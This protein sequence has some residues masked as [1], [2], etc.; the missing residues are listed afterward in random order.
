MKKP[1]RMR[2][3]EYDKFLPKAK[4]YFKLDEKQV[5]EMKDLRESG[6]PLK[7]LAEKFNIQILLLDN[8]KLFLKSLHVIFK[9]L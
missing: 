6:T 5:A 1:E 3:R 8:K 7:E 9:K 4:K 2:S